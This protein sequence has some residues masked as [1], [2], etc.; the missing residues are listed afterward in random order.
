MR[1]VRQYPAVFATQGTFSRSYPAVRE[2]VR[3]A[4]HEVCE[5]AATHGALDAELES[6]QAAV[7][8]AVANAVVHAY[9]AEPGEVHVTAA[10]SDGGLWVLVADDG[11]GFQTPARNPGLGWGLALIANATRELV[12][13]ERAGGG[14]EVRMRFSVGGD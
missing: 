3:L 11:C 4:R 14:T 2:A 10:A 12:V 5:F 13:A 7:S 8:E 1:R 6:V 9:R